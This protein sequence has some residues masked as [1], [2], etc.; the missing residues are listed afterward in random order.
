MKKIIRK[1]KDIL[2][3]HPRLFVAALLLVLLLVVLTIYR[4]ADEYL[5]Y[6]VTK[7]DNY[8]VYVGDVK[9][10]FEA[11]ITEN[12]LGEISKLEPKLDIEFGSLPIYGKDKVI[13]PTDMLIAFPKESSLPYRVLPYSYI[14]DN[15]LVTSNYKK[16]VNNYFMYDRNNTYFF[17]DNGVLIVDDVEYA[18]NKYSYVICNQGRVDFYD[19]SSDT[20]E[21]LEYE[22]SVIYKT[23][24]YDL[25]LANDRYANGGAKIPRELKHITLLSKR[26]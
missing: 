24:Y 9:Y 1:L 16:E 23:S 20:Y 6:S 2:T 17:G 7:N 15:T 12:R 4:I 21:A 26:G 14:I 8:Y 25:D 5:N 18:I 22:D 13:F 10:D 3:N 11:I 19:Y